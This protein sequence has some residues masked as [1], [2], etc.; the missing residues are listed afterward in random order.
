LD[1]FGTLPANEITQLQSDIAA[2]VRYDAV[3]SLTSA[4]QVQA[5]QNIYAAPLDALAFSGIQINGAFEISQE[6][7]GAGRATPGY[8][9]DGWMLSFSGSMAL[10]G[11]LFANGAIAGLP[12]S[13]AA[14]V[15]TAQGALAV[16]DYATVFQR[17][18]GYR[19]ARLAF[20][21][22]N[23]QP[24][25]IGFWTAH[26]RTGVYGGV[27]RNIAANRTCPFSYTQNAS[28][29][30]QYNIVTFP[31]DTAGTWNIDNSIAAEMYFTIAAGSNQQAPSAGAWLAGGWVTGPG[32]VNAVAAISDVFRLAGVIIVPGNQAPL[33]TS[34]AV[35]RT[36][37]YELP[38]CQRYYRK[39]YPYATALSATGAASCP[40]Y[41]VIVPSVTGAKQFL[42]AINLMPSMRAAPSVAFYSSNSGSGGTVYDAGSGTDVAAS[43]INISEKVFT[44]N[45]SSAASS[46]TSL[47]IQYH[48]TADARL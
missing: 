23:A 45:T 34:P 36:F 8:I 2:R 26:H 3:Q 4:Q 19:F 25:S 20:G 35:M 22:A 24:I 10:R 30:Y 39:S 7:G 16:N 15:V 21:T 29:T 44:L 38:L 37:D 18:E 40:N 5:R 14:T 28:D 31:G 41:F 12:G 47:N 27:L 43:A 6:L 9:C 11:T 32:Q 1:C 33:I 48:W 42:Q 13:I 46:G 17:I